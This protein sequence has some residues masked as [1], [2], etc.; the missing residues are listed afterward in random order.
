LL[1]VVIL[2]HPLHWSQI[3]CPLVQVKTM[4]ETESN[5]PFC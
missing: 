5:S 3:C 4:E 2:P 1:S